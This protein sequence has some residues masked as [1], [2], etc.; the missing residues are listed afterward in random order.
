MLK[1]HRTITLKDDYSD[2]EIAIVVDKICHVT[3]GGA[4]IYKSVF[5]KEDEIPVWRV[6]VN[7]GDANSTIKLNYKT[8][9]K[10][11]EVFEKILSE[12]NYPNKE[13]ATWIGI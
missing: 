12:T 4:V 1:F 3:K 9:K 2:Q 6:S 13:G 8:M 5:T 7:T 10:A 11:N